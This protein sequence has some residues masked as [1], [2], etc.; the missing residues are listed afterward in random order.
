MK[1][2]LAG[3]MTGY[4]DLNFP[5]FTEI[6]ALLRSIGHEVVNPAE[7]NP[8]PGTPWEQCMKEDIAVLLGCQGIAL[9]SGWQKSRGATLEHH[10]AQSL[11]MQV[12]SAY[13]LLINSN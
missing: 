10:I 12:V 7:V 6:A 9:L 4:P 8:D 13:E 1:L 2:Y 3:P 5:H 11:G